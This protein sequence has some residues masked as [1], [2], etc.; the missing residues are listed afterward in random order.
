MTHPRALWLIL[1]LITLFHLMK[2]KEE[3][4]CTLQKYITPICIWSF[5]SALLGF[6]FFQGYIY[7]GGWGG[8]TFNDFFFRNVHLKVTF[9]FLI[10][11]TALFYFLHFQ[12][13]Q[14]VKTK[15]G[16]ACFPQSFSGFGDCFLTDVKILWPFNFSMLHDEW[17]KR[18]FLTFLTQIHQSCYLLKVLCTS[19]ISHL[20]YLLLFL[21]CYIIL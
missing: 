7:L 15:S 21:V 1:L 11:K 5:L 8:L 12:H 17:F 2:H 18:S 20:F 10:F 4:T 16:W 14:M 19:K 3:A 13:F 9:P 6:I